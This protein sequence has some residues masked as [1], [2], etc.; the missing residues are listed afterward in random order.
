MKNT[1]KISGIG[2]VIFTLM[3]SCKK[4]EKADPLPNDTIENIAHQSENIPMTTAVF[5]KET[6]DFGDINK[7]EIVQHVYEI[8]NTGEK[9]LIISNVK[10]ACGCT[11][12]HYTQEPI[13]PG[14]KGKVTL[15]FDSKNFT[16]T[17]TKTAHVFIN[18]ENS[19]IVLSFKANVR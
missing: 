10:P 18:T 6:H 17:I 11:A 15:S 8:T 16:G 9:P 19:P 4:N 2:L 7:G 13:A 14:E 5:T 12:P 1:L 3:Y